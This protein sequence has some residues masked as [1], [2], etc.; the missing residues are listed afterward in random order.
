MRF[1]ERTMG[2][3]DSLPMTVHV[4]PSSIC[5]PSFFRRSF[6][7]QGTQHVHLVLSAVLH[8][9]AEVAIEL[10]G[11]EILATTHR[12][13]HVSWIYPP[14]TQDVS[15]HQGDMIFLVGNTKLNLHLPLACWVGG[16]SKM[17]QVRWRSQVKLNLYWA[18][19]V[20]KRVATLRLSDWLRPWWQRMGWKHPKGL[21]KYHRYEDSVQW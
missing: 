9:L 7:F 14:S 19:F 18:Q 5:L 4:L 13:G 2:N 1:L 21:W 11:A 17:Y 20:L 15:H 6:R 3:M 12:D 16:R 8:F 10:L